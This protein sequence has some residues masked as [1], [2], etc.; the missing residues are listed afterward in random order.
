[1]VFKHFFN[2]T[3][4][5]FFIESL[6]KKINHLEVGLEDSVFGEEYA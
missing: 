1:M 2:K 6:F 4:K 5:F 3:Y